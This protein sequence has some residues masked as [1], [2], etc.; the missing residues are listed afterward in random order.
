MAN[1]Y[2][3][4]KNSLKVKVDT[5][6]VSIANMESLEVSFDPTVETWYAIENGGYQSALKTAIAMSISGSAKRTYGDAGNDKIADTAFLVG[7]DCNLD[8][9]WT[10]PNGDKYDFTGVVSVDS[11]GGDS[12]AVDAISFSITVIGMPTEGSI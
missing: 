10:L 1:I 9:E 8:F 3:V 7:E 2:P 12:T 11:L 6:Y 4:N 5:S